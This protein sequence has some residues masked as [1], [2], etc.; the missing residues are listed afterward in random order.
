MI[1]HAPIR[2]IHPDILLRSKVVARRKK[3]DSSL[4][5]LVGQG[6]EGVV[7]DMA[8]LCSKELRFFIGSQLGEGGIGFITIVIFHYPIGFVHGF[9]KLDS[10]IFID[11]CDAGFLEGNLALL[12]QHDERK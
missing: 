1:P 6:R 4:T 8:V 11:I 3:G 2:C 9:E 10:G 12:V 5:L 7:A